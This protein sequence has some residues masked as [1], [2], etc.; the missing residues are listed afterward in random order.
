M[1]H[2]PPSTLGSLGHKNRHFVA[3]SLLFTVKTPSLF[4][5]VTSYVSPFQLSH[6]DPPAVPRAE[7]SIGN[8]PQRVSTAAAKSA[9]L[10]SRGPDW[11]T[12]SFTCFSRTKCHARKRARSLACLCPAHA[13]R[14]KKE[15]TAGPVIRLKM[16]HTRIRPL[17]YLILLKTNKMYVK[18]LRQPSR[19]S[20]ILA[21]LA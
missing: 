6:R 5:Q 13:T 15:K 14:Q 1:K 7:P 12:G 17:A 4:Q 20:F 18:E 8:S 10:A 2:S 16:Q 19:I 21:T 3:N 9:W 11:Q